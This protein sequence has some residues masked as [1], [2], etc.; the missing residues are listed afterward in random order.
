[1]HFFKIIIF[2]LYDFFDSHA[3][4]MAVV[5]PLDFEIDFERNP[6]SGS[7]AWFMVII[8]KFIFTATFE[9]K[10]HVTNSLAPKN[11]IFEARFL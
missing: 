4:G 6:I 5:Q 7:A 10:N 2:F 11:F 8:L 3:I 9:I 1:M